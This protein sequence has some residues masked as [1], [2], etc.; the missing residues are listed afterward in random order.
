MLERGPL[1]GRT[2]EWN[3]SRKEL[4]EVVSSGVLTQAE[5]YDC[6]AM[7]FN[8]VRIGFKVRPHLSVLSMKIESL[9][10]ILS[11]HSRLFP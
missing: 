1:K 4:D 3:I 9:K 6:I 7:E 11:K 8:P 5:A 10:K 2:Q